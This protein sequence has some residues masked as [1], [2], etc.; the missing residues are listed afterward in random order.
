MRISLSEGRKIHGFDVTGETLIV[1]LAADKTNLNHMTG[2]QIFDLNTGE[3]ISEQ[4]DRASPLCSISVNEYDQ[5]CGFSSSALKLYTLQDQVEEI[6][7]DTSAVSG[8]FFKILSDEKNFLA[9]AYG[10]DKNP[11]FW[12]VFSND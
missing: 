6:I 4:I 12:V 8:E 10:F 1:S 2:I 3:P 9:A 5:M 11:K 7:A